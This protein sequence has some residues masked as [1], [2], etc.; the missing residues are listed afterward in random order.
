[1]RN[2]LQPAGHDGDGVNRVTGKEQRHCQH[3]T[4]SHEASRV[5]TMHAMISENV[6]NSVAARTTMTS[7]L[8]SASGLQFSFTPRS[9]ER[10]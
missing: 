1:M 2:G 4:D 3:L 8:R 7:T 9:S 10:Q 6:E 5:F